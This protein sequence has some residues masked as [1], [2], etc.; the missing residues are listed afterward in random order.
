MRPA[1]LHICPATLK[2]EARHALSSSH[3]DQ[4]E[5]SQRPGTVNKV[6]TSSFNLPALDN[7]AFA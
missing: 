1:V 2:L 4:S 6:R 7:I 3:R 5:S